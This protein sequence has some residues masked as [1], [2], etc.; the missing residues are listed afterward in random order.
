MNFNDIT[1]STEQRHGFIDA[2]VL[3]AR[4]LEDN[5][6]LK[7]VD[8]TSG[9][10]GG[11]TCAAEIYFKETV[12]SLMA[13]RNLD[14]ATN[15][16]GTGFYWLVDEFEG[17]GKSKCTG[18]VPL[19]DFVPLSTTAMFASLASTFGLCP[20]QLAKEAVNHHAYCQG[21]LIFDFSK[22][23]KDLLAQYRFIS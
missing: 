6:Y 8:G 21:E 15:D 3:M 16:L 14:A 11:G 22:P 13:Y 20:E 4:C 2:S 7:A 9:E 1:T 23:K 10:V 12:Y 5:N 19:K 17:T 18:E